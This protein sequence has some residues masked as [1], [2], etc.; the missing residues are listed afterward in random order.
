MKICNCTEENAWYYNFGE[1]RCQYCDG[2][3]TNKNR[4]R[5]IIDYNTPVNIKNRNEIIEEEVKAALKRV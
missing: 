4:I 1:Y 5:K 2:I 3:L